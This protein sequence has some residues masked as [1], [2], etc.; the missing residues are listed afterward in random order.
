MRR[1]AFLVI[2]ALLAS[3]SLTSPALSASSVVL[4]REEFITMLS[5][6][7]TLKQKV[8]H[9]EQEIKLRIAANV[10]RDQLI[11][12][13]AKHIAELEAIVQKSEE[14]EQSQEAVR[15]ALE[16]KIDEIIRSMEREKRLSRYKSYGFVLSG[17]LLWVLS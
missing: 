14:I 3:V 4:D 7:E 12:L 10:E 5:H 15:V 16:T 2:W 11:T 6:V 13:Q 9:G 1:Y 17:I 8:G